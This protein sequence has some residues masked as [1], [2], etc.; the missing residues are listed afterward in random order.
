MKNIC[1]SMNVSKILPEKCVNLCRYF[2]LI[3]GVCNKED[4]SENYPRIIDSKNFERLTKLI[5]KETHKIKK[6]I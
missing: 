3:L 4:I 5:D 2:D 6:H 1:L